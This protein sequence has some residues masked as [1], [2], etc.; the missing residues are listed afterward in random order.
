MRAKLND[1]ALMYMEVMLGL[2]FICL[3]LP[4]STKLTGN[5]FVAQAESGWQFIYE[6][7]YLLAIF[8]VI[9]ITNIIILKTRKFIPLTMI[10]VLTVLMFLF[11]LDPI[12]A[13]GKHA[14]EYL[15]YGYLIGLIFVFIATIILVCRP[16]YSLLKIIRSSHLS[17]DETHEINIVEKQTL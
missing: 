3:F 17:L 7:K 1:I 8:I 10:R 11:M 13:Y 9:V 16:I 5:D 14:L 2:L 6:N 15:D 12:F 4:W